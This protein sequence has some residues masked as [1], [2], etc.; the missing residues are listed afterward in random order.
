MSFT[1]AINFFLAACPG[2]SMA[3]AGLHV[4]ALQAVKGIPGLDPKGSV[5]PERGESD[6]GSYLWSARQIGDRLNSSAEYLTRTAGKH[7]YSFARALRWIR[8][9]HG[10]A[11]L[12]EGCRVETVAYRLAFS[13]IAG[14]SR[15]TKRLVGRSPRQLPKVPLEIWIRKAVD[16]VFFGVP[17]S[18]E[19]RDG[20][21]KV[22]K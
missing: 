13:D 2:P 18:R 22:R 8:F 4:A 10:M 11:L 17:A 7:G 20:G 14:W 1:E 16:D 9:L 3:Q 5:T 12:A 15:F 6:A 21:T 19:P